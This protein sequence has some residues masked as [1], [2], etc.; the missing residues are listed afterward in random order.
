MAGINNGWICR[1][2]LD[3]QGHPV[4]AARLAIETVRDM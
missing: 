1:Y 3:G 2:R 4:L